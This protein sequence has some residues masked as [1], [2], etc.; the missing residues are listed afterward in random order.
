MS[1]KKLIIII[2]SIVAIIS[3]LVAIIVI[4]NNV[5]YTITFNSDGG[6]LVQKQVVKKGDKITKPTDPTKEGYNFV[7]W[8]YQNKTYDFS[9]EVTSDME[10]KAKWYEVKEEV[11]EYIV[12]FNTDGGTSGV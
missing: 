4:K 10:L 3:A 7:S 8:T 2:S 11:K 1:K 6:S 9:L 12:K 5:K